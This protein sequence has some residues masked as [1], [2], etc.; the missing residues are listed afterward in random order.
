MWP[1]PSIYCEYQTWP[2]MY[3][4]HEHLCR[5]YTTYYIITIVWSMYICIR[6]YF[7]M[8]DLIFNKTIILI[9]YI[10]NKNIMKYF[11]DC[12]LMIDRILIYCLPPILINIRVFGDLDA[13]IL[14]HILMLSIWDL[15]MM[16]LM[17]SSNGFFIRICH[18]G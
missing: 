7:R 17:V 9:K 1:N 13:R 2:L 3:I 8:M 16:L 5:W 15:N 4:A 12:N 14:M 11:W 10:Q 18:N 6:Y